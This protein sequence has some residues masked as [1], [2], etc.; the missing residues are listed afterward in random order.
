MTDSHEAIPVVSVPSPL[1]S[2][3]FMPNHSLLLAG[4]SQGKV[5]FFTVKEDLHHFASFETSALG[6]ISGPVTAISHLATFPQAFTSLVASGDVV[7]LWRVNVDGELKP[8]VRMVFQGAHECRVH[9]VSVRSSRDQFL[10]SDDLRVL[11]WDVNHPEAAFCI[12]DFQPPNIKDLREVVL[13]ASFH[14]SHSSLLVFTTTSGLIRIGDLR[15][16]ATA[17]PPILALHTPKKGAGPYGEQLASVTSANFSERGDLLFARDVRDVAIWDMRRACEP[18][19]TAVVVE[20]EKQLRY[21]VEKV[22]P[23]FG[24]RASAGASCITGGV[25]GETVIVSA[26]GHKTK[27]DLGFGDCPVPLVSSDYD[28]SLSFAAAERKVAGF[29]RHCQNGG[30]I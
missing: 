23:R 11:L 6:T 16:R 4:D 28:G 25:N 20:E 30:V 1:T 13:S 8:R 14:K 3:D 7:R 22:V 26:S 27:Q 12:A 29:R 5:L 9:S 24:V 21:L 10:S 17:M 15:V 19:A 2:L 18:V